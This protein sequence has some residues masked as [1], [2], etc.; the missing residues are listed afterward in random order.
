V[1]EVLCSEAARR[2]GAPLGGTATRADAWLLVEHHGPWGER[3]VEEND[4]PAVVQ[5]WMQAQ[6]AALQPLLGKARPLLVRGERETGGE[7]VCFLAIAREERQELYRFAAGRREDLAT[8]DLAALVAG[9]GG[10]L[11]RAR[12]ERGVVLICGNARRDRCCARFGLPTWRALAETMGTEAWLST[13]QGGHRYAST[14]LCLPEGV[15]YGFLAAEEVAPLV[16]ARRRGALHLRCFRGRTFHE[17]TVQAADV[18]LREHIGEDRLDAWRLSAADEVSPGAWRVVFTSPGARHAVRL[19]RDSE[20][21]LVSCTPPK[22]K[23]IDRFTL[24]AVE[25][26]ASV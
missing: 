6:L 9:G 26:E 17:A 11:A 7:V 10:A 14:G 22:R 5:Q 4:L 13:H 25:S 23:P 24:T 18:M 12:Q 2:E 20:E 19:R 16:A 1:N 15:A 8:L 21:V 3:A